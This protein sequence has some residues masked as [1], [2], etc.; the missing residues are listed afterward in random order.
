MHSTDVERLFSSGL[1]VYL[2]TRYDCVLEVY[3]S[4]CASS[5]LL[6]YQVANE[7]PFMEIAISLVPRLTHII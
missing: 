5:R 6:A 1:R 7:V 2:P 3:S 4:L